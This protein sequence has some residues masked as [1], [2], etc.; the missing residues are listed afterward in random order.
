MPL[1]RV[2]LVSF[3]ISISGLPVAAQSLSENSSV[4]QLLPTR[5]QDSQSGIRVDQ[6]QLS[7]HPDGVHLWHLLPEPELRRSIVTSDTTCYS[8]RTYRVTRDDPESDSTR[9][10]GYST[11]QP[12]A[13]FGVKD[14]EDSPLQKSV[15]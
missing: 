13:G 2:L 5:P 4:L 6:F 8:L 15:R 1:P 3:L 11:C 7:P 14:A 10:A 12:A 9:L